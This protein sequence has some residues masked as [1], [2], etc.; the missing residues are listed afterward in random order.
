MK[1][2]LGTSNFLEEI[3]SLSHSIVFLYVF[4]LITEGLSYLSVLFFGILHSNGGH[5]QILEGTNKTL[6]APGPRRKE[7]WHHKRLAQ[8]CL[9]VPR[10][11]CWRRG[12][13]VACYMVR[14]TECASACRRPFEGHCHYL[15][16]L[17]HSLV[18]G[19]TRE[20]NTAP[21]INRKIGLKI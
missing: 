15:H 21:P 20:G 14:G 11:L 7:Q 5:K 10:S 4:A 12:L 2:S 18:S 9:W 1:C 6:Y 3:S 8:T 17:H 13:A 16:Y 19:Q